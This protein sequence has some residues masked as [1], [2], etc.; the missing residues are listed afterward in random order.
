MGWKVKTRSK[1]FVLPKKINIRIKRLSD[2]SLWRK[3][4]KGMYHFYNGN[5]IG[6]YLFFIFIKQLLKKDVCSSNFVAYFS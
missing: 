2:I 4:T 3:S 1:E 6:L 5:T